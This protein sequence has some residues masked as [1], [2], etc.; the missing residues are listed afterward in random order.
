M[1]EDNLDDKVWNHTGDTDKAENY[2]KNDGDAGNPLSWHDTFPSSENGDTSTPTDVTPPD[3]TWVPEKWPLPATGDLGSDNGAEGGG[4]DTPV[5][6]DFSVDIGTLDDAQ[7]ALLPKAD[8]ALKSYTSL[9]TSTAGKVDWIFQQEHSGDLGTESVQ[10][11]GS[12]AGGSGPSYHDEKVEANAELVKQT[13][14]MKAVLD[15]M[16]LA[17]ADSVKLAGDYTSYINTAAQTYVYADKQA[18]I[19]PNGTPPA[20]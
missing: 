8:T 20:A 11:A 16:L 1:A 6:A 10:T 3:L 2:W 14:K 7:N 17:I 5:V 4:G 18:Y 13:P 12:S 9:K 15:N 19:K